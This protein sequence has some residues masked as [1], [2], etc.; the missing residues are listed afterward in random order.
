MKTVLVITSSYDNV[1][2]YL[3]TIYGDRCFFFR[4]DVDRLGDYS[5]QVN[6]YGWSIDNYRNFVTDQS[7]YSIY[8]RKPSFPNFRKYDSHSQQLM[9]K[10]IVGLIK[11]IVG[12]FE[13]KCLT[14]PYILEHAENKVYQMYLARKSGFMMPDSLVTNNSRCIRSFCEGKKSF[15]KPL[16]M[17][18]VSFSGYSYAKKANL[19]EYKEPIVGLEI[20]PTYFQHAKQKDYEVKATYICGK[21]YTVRVDVDRTKKMGLNE[22]VLSYSTMSL[23]NEVVEKCNLFMKNMNLR[24]GT[25]HFL[26]R[27]EEFYF[28]DINPNGNWLRL[29]NEFGWN[30]SADIIDYLC[31]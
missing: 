29:E 28:L 20:S 24:L 18:K 7:V 5:F 31:V 21:Y 26:V 13:G 19:I 17:G 11:G 27:E 30:L 4:L 10:D 3:T 25:F 14:K 1:V 16:G 23:P 8:Y 6:Q 12:T 2:D 15:I 22:E 9:K